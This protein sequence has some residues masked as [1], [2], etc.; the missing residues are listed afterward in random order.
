[1]TNKNNCQ[2]HIASKLPHVQTHAKSKKR[3]R[4][5]SNEEE[6][7]ERIIGKGEDDSPTRFNNQFHVH[8]RGCIRAGGLVN[9]AINLARKAFLFPNRKK[10]N[11]IK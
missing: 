8:P 6:T 4:I 1:M 9:E 7:K 11:K 2:N 5:T 10:K 3:Y